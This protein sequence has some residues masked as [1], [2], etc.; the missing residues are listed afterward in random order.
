VRLALGASIKANGRDRR[1]AGRAVKRT[2]ASFEVHACRT[3]KRFIL[4]RTGSAPA[5]SIRTI[6][7]CSAVVLQ[8]VAS[9]GFH[10]VWP[11]FAHGYSPEYP[12]LRKSHV[13]RCMHS[14]VIRQVLRT[15]RI[16]ATA[17]TCMRWS[18]GS[19]RH[20]TVTV[21]ITTACGHVNP[22]QTWVTAQPALEICTVRYVARARDAA[23]PRLTD[24]GKRQT[25]AAAWFTSRTFTTYHQA[26]PRRA[27]GALHWNPG[28][29]VP[30][31]LQFQQERSV[32][33]HACSTGG[34]HN[35]CTNR[36]GV[37]C[38]LSNPRVRYG[39]RKEQKHLPNFDTTV[40]P[41]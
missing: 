22:R 25:F 35:F 4:F 16:D 36:T 30:H 38:A 24:R 14:L 32:T 21:A 1:N 6:D 15:L 2:Q 33:P 10:A 3:R 34:L 27:R 12:C 26:S 37:S 39:A 5:R 40:V 7:V 13:V 29:L 8:Y 23:R 41:Q 9:S 20:C 17:A 31:T 18:Q 19:D 11:C 28:S